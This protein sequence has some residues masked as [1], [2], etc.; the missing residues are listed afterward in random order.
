MTKI[1]IGTKTPL[2]GNRGIEKND[3]SKIANHLSTNE[4][5]ILNDDSIQEI[6][7]S[8]IKIRS[9]VNIGSIQFVYKVVRNGEP[10][11]IEGHKF[12]GNAGKESLI[13]LKNDEHLIRIEG[14]YGDHPWWG[15]IDVLKF[16]T[17]DK[18]NGKVVFR[19][20]YG[21]WKSYEFKIFSERL[22]YPFVCF[23]GKCSGNSLSGLGMYEGNISL[24]A[25]KTENHSKKKTNDNQHQ[26]QI[27]VLPPPYNY[28]K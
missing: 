23:F 6:K 5:A 13:K 25:E 24:F 11:I 27:E 2:Y 18:S 21:G 7:V 10:H 26:A 15:N 8:E 16:W 22:I 3:L 1:I 9:G 28:K 12:G 17:Y 4:T 20:E 14:F 19:G